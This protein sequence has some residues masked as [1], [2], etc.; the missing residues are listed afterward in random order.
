MKDIVHL[1]GE[2]IS[3]SLYRPECGAFEFGFHPEVEVHF[4]YTT[5]KRCKNTKKYKKLKR[6]SETD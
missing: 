5:C 1:R 3:W 4:K 6:E 2:E